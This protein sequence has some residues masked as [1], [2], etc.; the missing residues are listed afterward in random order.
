M[1]EE[2]G[3]DAQDTIDK[4]VADK[5]RKAVAEDEPATV[6]EPV[7]TDK[8]RFLR[9]LRFVVHHA[10][11]VNGGS[12]DALL[13][14]QALLGELP[15]I[16]GILTNWDAA[17]EGTPAVERELVRCLH[18][19][20]FHLERIDETATK[21]EALAER[22]LFDSLPRAKEIISALEAAPWAPKKP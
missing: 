20:R 2:R 10:E 9:T 21:T 18:T 14:R 12:G 11:I 7:E 22:H 19:A 3:N 4:L 5:L 13:S 1:I 6:A 8:D 16:K 17:P 15:Y